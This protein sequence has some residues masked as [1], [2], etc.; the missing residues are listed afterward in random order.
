MYTGLR[1]PLNGSLLSEAVLFRAQSLVKNKGPKIFER[2]V[3]ASLSAKSSTSFTEAGAQEIK[4]ETKKYSEIL[5]AKLE[6][7]VLRVS[8]LIRKELFAKT[9]PSIPEVAQAGLIAAA[10]HEYSGIQYR[11]M[12]RRQKEG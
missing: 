6:T 3:F 2:Q 9:I 5:S 4:Y 12:I 11:V 7:A 1:I 8:Y 10:I